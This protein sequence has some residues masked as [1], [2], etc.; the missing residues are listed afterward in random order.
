MWGAKLLREWTNAINLVAPGKF[1]IAE[2]HSGWDAVTRP[3]SD[4]G[5]G[6][7]AA[8]YA[9]FYHHLAG[10][11]DKGSDYAKLLTSAAAL[12]RAPLAMGYFSGALQSTSRRTVVY[13]ESHDEAGN[14]KFSGRTISVAV[15]RAP[16]VG[17][18]RRY[19]EARCRFAAGL[20]LLS[21]GI[22]MF[23]MGEEVGF[24]KNYT[25]NGFVL[26]KEDFE[27]LK[28]A[29]GARLFRFY[30][31]LIGLRLSG[32]HE[33]LRTGQLSM[34]HVNNDGRTLVFERS[35]ANDRFLIV[36]SLSNDPYPSYRIN[37]AAL[38]GT[39]W[40][41][42]LSSD[43]TEYGG[44]GD[45]VSGLVIAAGDGTLDLAIPRCAIVALKEVSAS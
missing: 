22:P 44:W 25:Y 23:F 2:D 41:E 37:D 10:D 33:V 19:A 30:Q 34:L 14:S 39:R 3:T 42:M 36:A 6:F 40:Q 15:G 4:G 12:D 5:I 43:A 45:P 17:E 24:Q 27:G 38:R 8:W 18:T 1:L 32:E 9:D 31:D 21:A 29:D 26:E 20:N 28:A 35:R 7:D 16:L 11:T 13:S